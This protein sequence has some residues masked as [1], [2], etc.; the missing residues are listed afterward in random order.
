MEYNFRD[1]KTIHR[2]QV[3][4]DSH[5]KDVLLSAL[6]KACRRGDLA[7]ARYAGIELELFS[8]LPEAQA[9]VTNLVNRL[10][11][12]MIEDTSGLSWPAMINMF[13]DYYNEFERH[14]SGE[15]GRRRWAF[16]NMINLLVC[17]P[18]QRLISDIKA[19]YFTPDA[20]EFVM[21]SGDAQ[22][23]S[24]YP[25]EY[26]FDEQIQATGYPLKPADDVEGLQHIALGL[27][28]AMKRKS[29]HGFHWLA[30]LVRATESGVQA[31]KRTVG[32]S[33]RGDDNPMMLLFEMCYAY[34]R[35]GSRLWDK[36]SAN[37]NTELWSRKL[38]D[39]LNV[40]FNYYKHFGLKK[41]GAKK[42]HRD[43]IVF[44]IWPLL[45]CVRAVDWSHNNVAV[46]GTRF[47][48]VEGIY[49]AHLAAPP[50]VFGDY[51]YDQHT[52]KG[53]G[54]KRK[55][56]FFAEHGALVANEDVSLHN[57]LYRRVYNEFKKHQVAEA[58]K[59]KGKRAKK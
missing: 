23:L 37:H 52:A 27:L 25:V 45:Y 26:T 30:R 36:S 51:V 41:G 16:I 24:L 19:V 44:V 49:A 40:C 46:L 32:N 4:D 6:Q 3:A 50:M 43:W 14:R 48:E 21:T 11:V 5:K 29:D 34:A 8:S 57:P 10:R 12:I 9:I 13:D 38:Y 47:D 55:G 42:S 28:T 1:P 56:D 17:A 39:T 53:R 54:L 7:T 31:A 2:A 33:R 15:R 20:K 58:E 22:L 18:K 59:A 35:Q